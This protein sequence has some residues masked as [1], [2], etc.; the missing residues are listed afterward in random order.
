M[1]ELIKKFLN[2]KDKYGLKYTLKK[3]IIYL[4]KTILKCGTRRDE[5]WK[6]D[7]YSE[8]AKDVKTDIK[9]SI[10]V[11]LYNTPEIYLQEMVESVINQTYPNWELCLGDGSDNDYEHI[12]N[13]IEKLC[14]KDHRIKYVQINGNKG[15]A[16]NTI[17]AYKLATGDY[18]VLLDHDDLL[19]NTA[20]IELAKVIEERPEL[21]FIYS[22]RSIFDDK[23]KE[24]LAY[25]Y[26]PGY[27]PEFLRAC[28]YA[29][30]LNC[31]SKRIINEVG[32]LRMGYD[33][34]QD[35][36]IELRVIEKTKN[37]ANIPKVLYACRA[38]QGSVA[39]DP[40][41]K[42][43]AYEAGRRAIEEHIYR[44]GYPGEVEF[45]KD[46]F[47]YRIHYKIVNPGKT[48]IIIPNKDHVKDLER[49]INSILKKTKEVD[50]EIIVVEN[51][52]E[53][54]Q[55][56]LYYED[57]KKIGVRIL[58]YP[59]KTFNFS[60]INN[61]A[62]GHCESK[63][64]LFLNN[65]TEVIN[66]NW[67]KEMVMFAQRKDVG[68]V[69]AK[70]YYPNETYQHIGLYIGLGG[71]IASHYDHRKSNKETGYMHRLSMPQNY[72]AVTAACLLIKREDFKKVDGFDAVNF[73]IGLNDIDLCL[74]LREIGKINVL[75]P[76]A[77]L[78]HF[79]SISRGLD[80]EGESKDRFERESQFFRGKWKK[81]I[82][83]DE[84]INPNFK[85]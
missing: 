43:Y 26:L 24:I 13:K 14:E 69:G 41:S 19:E 2:N 29:S 66:E 5:I 30:H 32:F 3:T 11:P 1:N 60:D 12:K 28:N 56:F 45:L 59:G 34:S 68:A 65:D 51:N 38:C 16:G 22:D 46:T 48:S 84:Y 4:Y 17:E 10:I 15:I 31:F 83:K 40:E 62:V 21:D 27:S 35:Y 74:K 37:I 25:H 53:D 85:F 71:H 58:T 18:I 67:L 54:P 6:N 73:K 75:T 70:L 79:E 64:I 78:Y 9:F 47:S 61:F 42:M 44:I 76:Y 80:T 77:E 33:G 8:S 7:D 36:D 72:N 50:Y 49:C 55:T 39:L 57:L 20:L 63:Y 82:E 23:T 52:S 81:Y